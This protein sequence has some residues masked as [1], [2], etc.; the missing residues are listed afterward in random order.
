MAQTL[1][2]ARA[3]YAWEHASRN[4][5]TIDGYREMA[6]GAPALI[7]GSGLMAALAYYQSRTGSNEKPAKALLAD[8]LGWLADRKLVPN[9]FAAAM[10]CFFDASSA[11]YMQGT[12]EALAMLKWLRQFADAVDAGAD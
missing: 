2:Q 11:D 5:N 12:D 7:M 1:D 3:Q 4:T 10:K 8:L 9:D 6:K